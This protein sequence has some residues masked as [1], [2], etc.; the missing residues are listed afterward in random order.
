MRRPILIVVPLLA[1]ALA[2]CGPSIGDECESSYSCG[3]GNSCDLSVPGGYCTQTP[4]RNRGC[5]DE[6]AVC[7]QF[8]NGESYCM[9]A[10]GG[11]GDCRDGHVCQGARPR[12]DPVG[13]AVG[14]ACTEAETCDEPCTPRRDDGGS[15]CYV[16]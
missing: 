9:L 11:S 14:P 4:C 5:E 6:D 15:F 13:C 1:L 7:I 2:D 16:K 10:C 8:L 3:T 12:E